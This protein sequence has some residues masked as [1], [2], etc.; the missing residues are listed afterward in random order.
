[1]RKSAVWCVA[2]TS[3]V[4]FLLSCQG[5]RG[6]AGPAGPT[7]AAG[8]NLTINTV[9]ANA[10]TVSDG[11]TSVITVSVSYSG[12]ATLT[13]SWTAEAGKIIGTGAV[14]RWEAPEIG[15]H[16]VIS[17]TVSDGTN[18]ADGHVTVQVQSRLI[19][20]YPFDG[21]AYDVSG[22]GHHAAVSGATLANDRFGAVDKAYS[23]DGDD[24]MD[25]PDDP[26]LTLGSD[27]F[28]MTAWIQ[29]SA[30]S[31][32]AGYYLMGH[33]TGGGLTNKWIFFTGNSSI[34]FVVGPSPNWIYI[35][36][37]EF[38][39]DRWY[40]V[41]VRRSGSD[42]TAYVDGTPIGTASLTVSI[43]DPSAPL[44]IGS[45]ESAAQHSGRRFRGLI[46][47]VRIYRRALSDEEIV[48]FAQDSG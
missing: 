48:Q 44:Q 28:T 18:S 30:Y 14:V 16:Y 9:S 23:F 15:G 8:P 2:L 39:I 22:N 29:F 19:A 31:D 25:V 6:P 42:L 24:W 4:V 3:A 21:N 40:H 17:V 47:E 34:Q 26:G 45:A 43:P 46:D 41:A 13:Y 27:P 35:G 37:A 32:D 1:M 38:E 10:F 33:S 7:G 11:D 36:A 5:D 12:S 20:Y